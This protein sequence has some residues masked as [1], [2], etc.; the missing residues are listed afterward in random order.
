[1][2]ITIPPLMN[3]H[4]KGQKMTNKTYFINDKSMRPLRE[5]L[6]V[7]RNFGI[8]Y[9]SLLILPKDNPTPLVTFYSNRDWGTHFHRQKYERID[10]IDQYIHRFDNHLA[11]WMYLSKDPCQRAIFTE[12]EQ[13]YNIW[14]GI[15]KVM[16]DD[17]LKYAISIATHKEEEH[18][19]S[20]TIQYFDCINYFFWFSRNHLLKQLLL[21]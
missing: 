1:M 21:D 18:F 12:R 15:T 11:P 9:C 3:W 4:L 6:R 20:K 16:T 14:H 7:M 2:L 10:K 8:T 17:T 13:Q 5:Q 19:I